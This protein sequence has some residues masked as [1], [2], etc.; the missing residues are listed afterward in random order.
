MQKQEKIKQNMSF[1]E[2]TLLA[3]MQNSRK[4][5]FEETRS[6]FEVGNIYSKY[7]NI[8]KHSTVS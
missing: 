3:K 7:E 1:R 2:L 8:R 4:S 5:N 6:I